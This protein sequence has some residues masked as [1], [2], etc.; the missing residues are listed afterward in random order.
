MAVDYNR[1][2]E[3]EMPIKGLTTNVTAGFGE[4]GK[5]HKGGIRK[6]AKRADG[7]EYSTMGEDLQYFRFA[8]TQP[9]IQK[10]FLEAYGAQPATLQVFL[11]F[12]T[13]EEN[14]DA[15]KELWKAGGLVH[16]CDGE[17]IL[18]WYNL[19]KKRFEDNPGTKCPTTDK[20]PKNEQCKPIGRLRL[21]LPGLWKAGYVGLVTLCTHSLN[22]IVHIQG[23]L[24]ATYEAGKNSRGNQGLKGV[25]FTLSRRKVEISTPGED[26]K[27]VRREKWLVNLEP[28][29][30]WVILQL[31]AAQRMALAAL[32]TKGI[33]VDNE[34]EEIEVD[35][36]VIDQQT[37]EVLPVQASSP[38]TQ[39]GMTVINNLTANASKLEVIQK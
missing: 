26:G 27:R 17:N 14:W 11:P 15:F 30:N 39:M 28:S 4:L 3:T 29:S 7:S 38:G 33:D 8:A 20:T 32:E 12:A 25:E 2:K 13:I 10:A 34:D 23:V 9:P 16:R 31:E 24:M 18:R 36:M 21:I 1:G 5:L 6:T 19:E 35:G 22:D 37:G